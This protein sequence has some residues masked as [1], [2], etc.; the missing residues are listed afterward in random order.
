M[1]RIKTISIISIAVIAL[2]ALVVIS[3]EKEE[4]I[5]PNTTGVNSNTPFKARTI[6]PSEVGCHKK[7]TEWCEECHQYCNVDGLNCAPCVIVVGSALSHQVIENIKNLIDQSGDDVAKFFADPKN[8]QDLLP[9]LGNSEDGKQF[10]RLLQS[11]KYVI[12]D[13]ITPPNGNGVIIFTSASLPQAITDGETPRISSQTF[14]IPFS[15]IEK[16]V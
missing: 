15:I 8:Y 6:D 9:E 12:K 2:T 5:L 10:L 7:V 3:C 14:A 4:S 13:V 11:S 16:N 1:K